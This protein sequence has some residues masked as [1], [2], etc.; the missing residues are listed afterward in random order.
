MRRNLK[1]RVVEAFKLLTDEH[2]SIEFGEEVDFPSF[3]AKHHLP[4]TKLFSQITFISRTT[5]RKS[6]ALSCDHEG[7]GKFFKKWHNLLDHL[8]IHTDE[9]PFQCP[10]QGCD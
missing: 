5:A 1:E 3:I 4:K 8:R 7:C 10:I 9:K 2:I 6:L